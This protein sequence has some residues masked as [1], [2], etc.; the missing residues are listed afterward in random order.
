MITEAISTLTKVRRLNNGRGRMRH[1]FDTVGLLNWVLVGN[2]WMFV[3]MRALLRISDWVIRNLEKK[4][5]L[6]LSLRN[7]SLDVYF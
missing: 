7:L 4:E 3:F 5:L 6:S 1:L 2:A